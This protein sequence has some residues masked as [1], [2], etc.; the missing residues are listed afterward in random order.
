MKTARMRTV[1]THDN[2]DVVGAEDTV[3]VVV[4]I[5]EQDVV[6]LLREIQDEDSQVDVVDTHDNMDVVGTE[7]MVVVVQNVVVLMAEIQ[8]EECQMDVVDT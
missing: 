8:R 1:G 3:V 7:D 6:V 2:M 5:Y 4:N